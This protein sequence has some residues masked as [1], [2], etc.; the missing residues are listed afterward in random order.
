MPRLHQVRTDALRAD[1]DNID[2]P[3]YAKLGYLSYQTL[4]KVVL[5]QKNKVI[6]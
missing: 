3:Y 6:R 2:R 5:L 4:A 1:A